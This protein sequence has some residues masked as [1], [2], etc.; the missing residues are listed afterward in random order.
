MQAPE[1]PRQLA[2]AGHRV[3]D[4]RG[5]D[6]ARVR[7]DEEDRRGEEAD[8]DLEH[9]EERPADAE[10]LDDAEH[11]VGR[12]LSCRARVTPCFTGIAERAIIGSVK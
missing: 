2:V 6:H 5:A 4:P 11:R 1:E 3:R 12:E 7:R 10:V 9:G 8:V